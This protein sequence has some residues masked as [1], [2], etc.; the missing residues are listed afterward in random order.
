[1]NCNRNALSYAVGLGLAAGALVIPGAAYAQSTGATQLDRI[2]VTGSRIRQVD[3]ETAQPV[4]TITRA[5]I[6][7]QGFTSVADILQNISAAGAPPISR[8]SPLSAGEA[9]GGQYISLRNLGTTR[10]LVLV[11]GRR[12][13]ITTGGNQDISTIPTSAVERIEVLKDGASAI[14][15]SDAMAGVV[16]IITRSSFEGVQATAYYGQY[17][18]GDG[19]VE[20]F[21]VTAGTS[22]D[23]MSVVF[24]FEYS[25]E[26]EVWSTD[27]PYTEFPNGARH[28]YRGWTPASSWGGWV[29]SEETAVPGV[30]TGTR[31]VLRPGGD[32]RNI[33]D[34]VAQDT[35]APNGQVNNANEQMHLRNPIERKQIFASGSY[36]LTDNIR[37]R[38]DLLYGKRDASRSIAGYPM[39]AGTFANNVPGG[40]GISP[41]S[42]FN[43][44]GAT[45]DNWW[46]RTWE[47]PRV[48]DNSI[49]N[50]RG[51]L[52][53][54]G[55]FDVGDRYFDWDV[56][57]LYTENKN[58]QSS[59]GN[60]NLNNVKHAVG[61]SYITDTGNL[62]CGTPDSGPIQGCVPWNVFLPYGVAGPGSFVDNQALMDYIFQEEHSTGQTSTSVFNANIA[63]GIFT[64][65]AGDLGFAAGIERR[66][67]KGEFVPDALS[68]SGGSTNLGARP[69]RGGYNV[70][71]AYAELEIPLLADLPGARELSLNVATR[72]SDFDTF[73]DT[74]NSKA[75]FKWKPIDQLLIRGTWAEGFRAPTVA[76]LYAGGS[77]TFANY[78]DVCDT[79]YGQAAGNA[80]IR[81]NCGRD[82]A[83]PDT[84]R[85][86]QQGFVQ[87]TG[88][89]VQTPVPFFSGAA[90]PLLTPETSV[91]KN[92]GVV[93]SPTFAPT[94]SFALDWWNV[95][96][97]NTIV[98]DTPGD[99]LRDCYVDN[100]MSRCELFTRDPVLGYINSMSYGSRNSGYLDTE[101]FDFDVN[102]RWDTAAWGNF[103]FQFNS[104]Y[105]SKFESKSTDIATQLPTQNVGFGTYY[106]IRANAGIDWNYGIFAASWNFR[107]YH[108]TSETCLDW[109]N[110]PEE[111]SNPDY[112]AGNPAQ[113]RA[114]N[115]MSSALF[116]DV[117]FRV[118][119]P[120]DATISVGANNVFDRVASPSYSQVNS[121]F[122]YNGEFD[123]GRFMYMRYQ[124]RF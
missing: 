80:T 41:D 33:N 101:G 93:W 1:M 113:T 54:E 67:E 123:I 50:F 48:T 2:E 42:Y 25:K 57:Y 46:R 86:L 66:K 59:F 23:R 98:S 12:L 8:A 56:S 53:L 21:D 43:P 75:S 88:P 15:G 81:A 49:D 92:L 4:L 6:E 78:T 69:T 77:Q 118:N 20:R 16:N 107:Y 91:S 99:I 68:V 89:N 124:Q 105:V 116:N 30:P 115:R 106:R 11:N 62:V 45:I 103:G 22:S 65:P 31:V 47:V 74:L 32:P 121:N 64:L 119:A 26:N 73:G 60:L 19:A 40:V 94:L 79:V 18:E 72:Y 82:I 38:G 102:Y 71:E 39:Q 51:V 36:E 27:R 83:N 122:A 35:T 61:P 100:I 5:E 13:G 97:E 58:L 34:Y 90:N 17:S 110:V 7:N 63:G 70:N 44:T 117:Q 55:S 37:V 3:I 29:T 96:I 52:A 76:N 14:Y 112:I 84:F 111:C 87:S 10:S 28:P 9:V 104:T 114:I 120:W 109:R 108:G 85:Q 95:R 24:G